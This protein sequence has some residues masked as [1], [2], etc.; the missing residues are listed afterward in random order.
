MLFAFTAINAGADVVARPTTNQTSRAS[1]ARMPSI[2]AQSAQ[3]SQQ[4]T[5]PVQTETTTQTATTNSEQA[6]P[7]EL[8]PDVIENKS[9]QFGTVLTKSS[10]SNSDT[11]GDELAAQVRTQR[12]ALD[13][14]AAMSDTTTSSHAAC[15]TGLR[16]CM[17][18][19][20]GNNFIK[21]A[22]DTDTLFGTKLDSC[23]RNLKCNANEFKLFSAEIKADRATA[24]KLK[25]FNDIIDCG[26]RYDTC[27]VG[28][29]GSTYSKCL[30][31]S[32][33]DLAISKCASIEK[34]CA[35]MDSGL[36][37][38]T[39]DV[40]ATLRQTAEKQISADEKK[41]YAMRDQMKSVCSR[42]GA[43]FDERSLD[44]VYTIN[45][46][47]G[48]DSTL[49]ASKKAYAGS[50]F[51][52]SPN[53]FGIDITTF[54]ENAYR[55]TREQSA[56]SSAMLGSGVGMAVGSITS[57]AIDRAIERHD[58]DVELNE[59]KCSQQ[60]GMKWNKLLNKCVKDNS[61]ERAE[62]KSER[63][64]AREERRAE[65]AASGDTMT[66]TAGGEA[67]SDTAPQ[68]AHEQTSSK[69]KSGR[70][71]LSSATSIIPQAAQ[72]LDKDKLPNQKTPE[73]PADTT[74]L[75]ELL[76]DPQKFISG[77]N[78]SV[79]LSDNDIQQIKNFVTVFKRYYNDAYL[80]DNTNADNSAKLKIYIAS[81]TMK[82]ISNE[83]HAEFC[84]IT[85]H[86]EV[87]GNNTKCHIEPFDIDRQGT[88]IHGC[89]QKFDR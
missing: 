68:A 89:R 88:R 48:G 81:E 61:T 66:E 73:T 50:T 54:R 38:R 49:Y 10:T 87:C 77:K 74:P 19:K 24:I 1:I 30:G 43:M 20:C 63:T 11:A 58:A 42:L 31:K 57:G 59:A 45:F 33:G 60:D 53:W 64:Q 83:N 16:E 86:N 2:S 7:T 9:A 3:L 40:F 55:L 82:I 56:A 70:G 76:K 21:C 12:A 4:Q 29:C 15:D 37:A 34:D 28:Q 62:K 25:S 17:T 23:R 44:C 13:A 79:E 27:I 36:A 71:V 6:Q 32:A 39:M 46:Y 47:A 75:D 8:E 51:D 78:L 52:C 5:Q 72:I 80:Y 26:Q 18:E 84:A 35:A 67:S 22:S 41:L 65:R 85:I 14:A 69:N